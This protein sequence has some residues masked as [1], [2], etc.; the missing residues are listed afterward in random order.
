MSR[1]LNA[2]SLWQ[3]YS[4]R[5][6]CCV[7]LWRHNPPNLNICIV[8]NSCRNLSS[9]ALTLCTSAAKVKNGCYRYGRQRGHS[10]LGFSVSGKFW[11]LRPYPQLKISGWEIDWNLRDPV[12]CL[13]YKDLDSLM[14]SVQSQS[15]IIYTVAQRVRIRSPLDLSLQAFSFVPECPNLLS[16]LQLVLSPCAYWSHLRLLHCLWPSST[17]SVY[18]TL[19][20]LTTSWSCSTV[21]KQT[22]GTLIC[23]VKCVALG[24][25]ID[26]W[27]VN[28]R[29]DQVI[30]VFVIYLFLS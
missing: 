2:V 7:W 15:S 22:F 19:I 16:W 28:K 25:K 26:L 18:I 17:V 8:S 20:F 5:A 27:D 11:I 30:D 3:I 21:G 23:I 10:N 13:L 4:S 24:R 14:K 6:L 9:K 29:E 1:L 12:W